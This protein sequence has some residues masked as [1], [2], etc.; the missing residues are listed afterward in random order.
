MPADAGRGA[1]F[2]LAGILC[3]AAGGPQKPKSAA[4]SEEKDY[5][6]GNGARIR[7]DRRGSVYA[8]SRTPSGRR[9][10]RRPPG[11]SRTVLVRSPRKVRGVV[12]PLGQPVD[13][14]SPS[15]GRDTPAASARSRSRRSRSLREH[16]APDGHV[17]GLVPTPIPVGPAGC[18]GRA[19][20]GD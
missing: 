14:E 2:T 13:H 3:L 15:A 8:K 6:R 18:G 1:F 12:E 19:F 20:A 16:S 4:R 10:L 9:R 11:R 7:P 17:G 5:S